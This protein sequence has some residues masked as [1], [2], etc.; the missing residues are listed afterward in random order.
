MKP[1]RGGSPLGKG[2][3]N[4]LDDEGIPGLAMVGPFEPY[5]HIIQGTAERQRQG[6]VIK[7]ALIVVSTRVVD[8][9]YFNTLSLTLINLMSK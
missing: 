9:L 2:T 6:G 5:C 1:Q 4:T 8:E 3:E 7:E